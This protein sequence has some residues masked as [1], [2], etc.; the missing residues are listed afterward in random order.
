MKSVDENR[1]LKVFLCHT[2]SDKDAVKALY[3][4]LK[5]EGVDVWLD[6]EKLLPGVDWELEIRKAV[7]EADVVVVCLSK[8]F[9]QAGFRQ[10]EVRIA[11]D[12]A[13][14]KPEGEIFI[15]PARLE[16]CDTLESLRKWHWVD[17]FESD[18]YQRLIRALRIRAEK[19]GATLRQRGRASISRPKIKAEQEAAEKAA[20]EKTEQ[21][22]ANKARLVAEELERQRV[23][24]EQA[25]HE[26]VEKATREKAER[27]AAEKARLEAEELARQKATKEKAEREAAE[28]AAR[29]KARRDNAK[30]EEVETKPSLKPEIQK[31]QDNSNAI[32]WVVGGILVII[33]VVWL[34]SLNGTPSTPAPTSIPTKISTPTAYVGSLPTEITPEIILP[35]PS[36]ISIPTKVST[37]TVY[38]GSLPTEI[39]DEDVP[40]RLVPAGE[41]TMG[42]EN[43]D[44][45][46]QPVHTVYLGDFYMDKYEVTNA[47]YKAC[48]DAGGCKTPP[49]NYTRDSYYGNS[50]FDDYPVIV[51]WNQAQAYCEWRG[52]SLPTESQW[53]KA[54]HGTDGRTYPW[55]EGID[56]TFANYN[57]FVGNTSPVGSYESGQSPYG[58]YDLAGNVWEWTGSLYKPYPYVSTDGR[59]DLNASGSRVVRGGSWSNYDNVV[60]SAYRYD[61]SPDVII[62]LDVGFRCVR[63]VP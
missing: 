5:R 2:H 14:E 8:Q 26:E 23:I 16:E 46:E 17:L 20:R 39:T 53:E 59:E 9:N 3:A 47:L 35:S 22:A 54:A 25:D 42:S 13:M 55:G 24:K 43:G 27:D 34:S 21:D 33:L 49:Q 18:G 50:E 38:V 62:Y 32:F 28:K 61:Y 63:S 30:R 1:A 4:R 31:P 60:R 44:S 29:Q 6:K 40:M 58:I 37:P 56:K 36:P 12:A 41:F 51:E 52:A 7:R 11:L 10:K 15:I 48:V 19:I 45:N 57:Q